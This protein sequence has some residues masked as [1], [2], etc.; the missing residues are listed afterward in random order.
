MCVLICVSLYRVGNDVTLVGWGTQV[1][2]LLEVADL[3][4]EKLDASCE[5]IDLF[6]ILPWDA[7]LVCKVGKIPFLRIITILSLRARDRIRNRLRDELLSLALF[8]FPIARVTIAITRLLLYVRRQALLIGA[9][10]R[11]E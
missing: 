6:S 9:T 8:P 5:V 4:R 11:V 2:V 7:E 3:V 1:H 10:R